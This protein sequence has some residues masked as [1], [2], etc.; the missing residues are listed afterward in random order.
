LR[1]RCGKASLRHAAGIDLAQ[2]AARSTRRAD[3][4]RRRV[5]APGAID[6]AEIALGRHAVAHA[7]LQLGNVGEAAL[8]LARPNG[9]AADADDEDAAGA[10]NECHAPI[11]SSNVERISCAIQAARSSQ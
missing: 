1:F 6:M 5:L 8:V 9:L 3:A 2:A 11:S 10:G 7:L 4:R